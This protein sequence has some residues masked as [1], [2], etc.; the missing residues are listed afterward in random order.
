MSNGPVANYTFKPWRDHPG[1]VLGFTA[2]GPGWTPILEV[3]DGIMKWAIESPDSTDDASI[4]VVQ[5]KEKFGGL[6][7]YWESEGLGEKLRS[8][9]YGATLMA[10][11]MS[12]RTCEKCGSFEGA[13]T[14]TRRNAQWYGGRTL[15]LCT[16]CHEERNNSEVFEIGNG[17]KV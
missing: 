1:K 2:V 16:S 8:E 4:K 12:L 7:I 17:D 13:R 9:V 6:R 11:A 3:V 14:C 15:T 5:I 10:E